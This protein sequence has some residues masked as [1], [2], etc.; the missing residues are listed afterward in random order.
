MA[1]IA[2]QS[3]Q[4]LVV[5]ALLANSRWRCWRGPTCSFQRE[6]TFPPFRLPAPSYYRAVISSPWAS[7]YLLHSRA[8]CGWFAGARVYS[9]AKRQPRLLFEA[10]AGVSVAGGL[11]C[12]RSERLGLRLP[13]VFYFGTLL[14]G[15]LRSELEKRQ[16]SCHLRCFGRGVPFSLGGTLC[17]CLVADRVLERR[18]TG[19]PVPLPATGGQR[20]LNLECSAYWIAR[21]RGYKNVRCETAPSTTGR[22]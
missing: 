3:R 19:A 9:G 4:T 14:P 22:I 16:L 2:P 17:C 1:W 10:G 20:E 6:M 5:V 13:C 21:L 7:Q 15:A 18:S 12:A 8:L 11:D